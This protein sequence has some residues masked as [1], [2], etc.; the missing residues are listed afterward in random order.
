VVQG[1][2][3]LVMMAVLTS[4]DL[5][6]ERYVDKINELQ[7]GKTRHPLYH[8]SVKISEPLKKHSLL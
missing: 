6:A 7:V 3:D 4:N 5:G 2:T 1:T 8:H